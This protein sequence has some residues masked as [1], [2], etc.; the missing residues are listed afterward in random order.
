MKKHLA[1]IK[2]FF[3]Y[4]FL[5]REL[6]SRDIKV[7]YKRSF[8]GM[9]W[10]LL[11]PLMM[12]GVMTFVFS[13]LFKSDIPYFPVYYLTGNV[14]FSFNSEATNQAMVSV[15]GN[16]SLLKKVYIPKYLFPL[17]K[18][19]SS[20]VNLLFS[21]IALILVM[22]I[23]RVPFFPTILLSPIPILYQIM[24][25][26]GLSLILSCVTVFFRDMV[27]LYS[28]V[29]LA[30]MYLTPLFYPV[31]IIP[32]NLRWIMSLNPL[33][34]F[35]NYMRQL[36]L[37]NQLPGLMENLICFGWGLGMLALGLIVF[38]RLQDKFILHI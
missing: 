32:G 38:Y 7:K 25:T 24:F 16:A 15:T 26:V 18:V 12:M 2:D 20:M 10:T 27:H 22:L 11:N 34:C 6:V 33:Y 9:L 35:I 28:V 1:Y 29:T 19:L 13:N 4:S 31:S 30:W 17:S 8:L 23:L 21:F 14:L 3:N 36:I 5:L 37:G